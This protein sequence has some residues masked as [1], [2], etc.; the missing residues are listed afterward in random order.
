MLTRNTKISNVI[1]FYHIFKEVSKHKQSKKT[2]K[3]QPDIS[4]ANEWSFFKTC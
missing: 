4:T 1:I 2:Q 3:Q